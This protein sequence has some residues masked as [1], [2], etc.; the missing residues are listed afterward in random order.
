MNSN[1]KSV[2]SFGGSGTHLWPLSLE[3]FPRQLT[4]LIE[5]KNYFEL[6][7]MGAKFI[8]LPNKSF[9]K[10]MNIKFFLIKIQ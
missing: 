1:I 6:N 7:F 3:P 10:I 5:G 4:L 2:F 9:E 8:R